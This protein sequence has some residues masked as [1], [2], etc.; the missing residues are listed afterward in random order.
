LS[1]ANSFLMS[2][3]SMATFPLVVAL[4]KYLFNF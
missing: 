4:V 1:T 2:L 3:L